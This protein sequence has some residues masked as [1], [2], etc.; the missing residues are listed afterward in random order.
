MSRLF[1][2]H[3]IEIKSIR[4]HIDRL[5]ESYEE[6]TDIW[7]LI[8]EYVNNRILCLILDELEDEYHDE[9]L[10]MFLDRPYD[11]DIVTYLNERLRTPLESIIESNL[12]YMT[13][14]LMEVLEINVK[15]LEKKKLKGKTTRHKD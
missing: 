11:G 10:N 4:F 1:Y 15:D 3:L 7:N 6:K 13:S 9:F 2:D 12:P 14:E 8:D 5:S